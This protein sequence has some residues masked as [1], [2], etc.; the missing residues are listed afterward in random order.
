MT[1]LA[2]DP[3]AVDWCSGSGRVHVQ[4]I[5]RVEVLTSFGEFVAW[6]GPCADADEDGCGWLVACLGDDCAGPVVWS[7][8][9]CEAPRG[10]S[11]L[12]RGAR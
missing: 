5:G 12:G 10:E 9:D 3:P 7:F 2:T 6:G 8:E 4:T 1:N 11:L